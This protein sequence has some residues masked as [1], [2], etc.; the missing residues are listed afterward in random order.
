[1]E[2]ETQLTGD[3]LHRAMLLHSRLR[4]LTIFALAATLVLAS[5]ITFVLH[6]SGLGIL[7]AAVVLF[8]LLRRAVTRFVFMPEWE[9]RGYSRQKMLQAP[10]QVCVSEGGL[11]F[12]NQYGNV[13]L[14]WDRFI[15]WKEDAQL[16][17]L[18]QSPSIYF[19]IPKRSF[20][21]ESQR[22]QFMELLTRKRILKD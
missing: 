4:H 11:Q 10:L 9:L 5:V 7:L 17:L 21:D 14:T 12:V 2:F 6:L 1:M 13:H 3:D 16:F 8:I 22:Q 15:G 20:P 19:V 18:Y